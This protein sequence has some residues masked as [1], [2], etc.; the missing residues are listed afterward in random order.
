[1]ETYSNTNVNSLICVAKSTSSFVL[2]YGTRCS[3]PEFSSP[4]VQRSS[5]ILAFGPIDECVSSCICLR[6]SSRTTGVQHHRPLLPSRRGS[7]LET[8]VR[9]NAIASSSNIPSNA[10]DNS[11]GQKA[12]TGG[13]VC[14]ILQLISDFLKSYSVQ[15]HNR[16][17]LFD[18]S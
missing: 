13:R 1:V 17:N 9:T 11:F 2:L 6:H 8:R 4:S 12:T 16:F 14:S 10:M 3:V 18:C 15:I 5:Y 7:P